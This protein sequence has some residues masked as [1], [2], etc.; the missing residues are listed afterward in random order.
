MHE[1]ALMKDLMKRIEEIA[2][3]EGSKRVTG[4]KVKLGALSHMTPE[5]FREHFEQVSRGTVAQGAR[6]E[7]IQLNDIRDPKATQIELEKLEVED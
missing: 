3:R 2:A 4:L 1:A 5:H 7:A 6:V